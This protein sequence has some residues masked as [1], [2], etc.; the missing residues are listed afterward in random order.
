MVINF[1]QSHTESLVL[2]GFSCTISK[3]QNT[4]HSQCIAYVKWYKHGFLKERDDHTLCKVGRKV[5]FRSV[6]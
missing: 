1:V 6:F 4:G 5:E 3:F 2:I